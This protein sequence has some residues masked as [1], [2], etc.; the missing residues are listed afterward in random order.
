[1]IMAEAQ[2]K[3]RRLRVHG[4]K[5]LDGFDLRLPR[6]TTILVGANGAGKSTLLQCL[7]FI[8]DFVKG[9]PASFFDDRHWC[10]RDIRSRS[11]RGNAMVRVDIALEGDAECRYF[12]HFSWDVQ[13]GSLVS[14]IITR[15]SKISEKIEVLLG[16]GGGRGLSKAQEAFAVPANIKPVGS[17]LSIVDFE[18]LPVGQSSHFRAI[19]RWAEGIQPLELLCPGAMRRGIRGPSGSIGTQGER[20]AGFLS[21]LKPDQKKRLVER[22]GQYF[23]LLDYATVKKVAGWID[24]RIQ[25]RYRS[26]GNVN[27]S[28]MSDGFLRLLGIAAIPEFSGE[29][30]LILLDEIENG[31]A[32]HILSELIHRVLKAAPA[33]VLL[34]SQAPALVNSFDHAEICFVVRDD[35]GRSVAARFD[36]IKELEQPPDTVGAGEFWCRTSPTALVGMIR[37]IDAQRKKAK[38][39]PLDRTS[40]RE[41]ISQ[42]DEGAVHRGLNEHLLAVIRDFMV[43][44]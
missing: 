5:S 26:F 43:A 32:P 28:H 11:G 23:P 39:S 25:E 17:Y 3:L 30:S 37:L 9:R 14:E 40:R 15:S 34:T 8:P 36:E 35:D 13:T 29:V 12:W 18:S 31:I 1:M 44:I 16:Y 33:Q 2:L 4:F 41:A 6:D 10:A 7:A 24:L 42:S 19:R 20:L 27:G 21:A 22:L 38:G